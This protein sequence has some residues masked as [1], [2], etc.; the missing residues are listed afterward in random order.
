[1][2]EQAALDMDKAFEEYRR[3]KYRNQAYPIDAYT[4]F[5]AGWKAAMKVASHGEEV[6]TDG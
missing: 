1:M 4:H 2:T 5:G 6:K 3:E